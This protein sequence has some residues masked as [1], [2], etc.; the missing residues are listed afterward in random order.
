[1]LYLHQ[2][3]TLVDRIRTG[4]F[5]YNLGICPVNT[6]P[7]S[8]SKHLPPLAP[9]GNGALFPSGL[10]VPV[11]LHWLK[12]VWAGSSDTN[13]SIAQASKKKKIKIEMII[14]NRMKRE[15]QRRQSR[16]LTLSYCTILIFESP[17]KSIRVKSLLW[18]WLQE[19]KMKTKQ[20]KH[21]SLANFSGRS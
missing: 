20:S 11:T 8:S 21:L 10:E 16:I 19:K 15:V 12:C 3:H 4:G 5:R 9:K 1:M 7:W 6:C 13:G 14:S 18:F 2:L 17:W